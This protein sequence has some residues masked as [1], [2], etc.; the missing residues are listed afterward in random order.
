L[1][2][3]LLGPLDIILPPACLYKFRHAASLDFHVE[4]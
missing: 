3:L 4:S 2:N 1:D